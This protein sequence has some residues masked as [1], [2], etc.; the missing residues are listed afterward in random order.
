MSDDI[1]DK[2]EKQLQIND[3]IEVIPKADLAYNSPDPSVINNIEDR[4]LMAGPS[5]TF[6]SKKA[7]K[8]T[9]IIEKIKRISEKQ[10]KPCDSDKSLNR[11]SKD[12][13]NRKLALLINSGMDELNGQ[14]DEDIIRNVRAN[15]PP[16]IVEQLQP[17]PNKTSQPLSLEVGA[18]SLYNLNMLLANVLQTVNNNAVAE[19]T[20]FAIQ[21]LPD[22]LESRREELMQ[23]YAEVYRQYSTEI[24]TYISPINLILLINSQCVVASIVKAETEAVKN[25]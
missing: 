20:G 8:K 18:K 7:D 13:L 9:D 25:G 14:R 15:D 19:Y 16:Y 4:L 2:L 10:G 11:L 21:K 12:E 5:N 23:L 1:L 22:N 6:K 24:S 3:N 17:A